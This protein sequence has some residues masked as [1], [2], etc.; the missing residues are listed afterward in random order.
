MGQPTI[1]PAPPANYRAAH[2]ARSLPPLTVH[3]GTIT[4]ADE[5]CPDGN[6]TLAPGCPVP[7]KDNDLRRHFASLLL[8]ATV[9]PPS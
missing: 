5:N 4:P 3:A 8:V 6:G 2:Q 9:L 7:A 1:A